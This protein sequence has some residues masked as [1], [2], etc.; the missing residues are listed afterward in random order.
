LL[1]LG[2][3]DRRIGLTRSFADALDDPR[4][5]GLTEHTFL[6]MVRARAYD[7]LAGYTD[8][9]DHNTL[10]AGPVFKRVA[11]RS[12]EDDDLASQPTLPRCE[13]AIATSSAEG[14]R[15]PSARSPGAGRLLPFRSCSCSALLGDRPIYPSLRER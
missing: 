14:R 11:G 5:P 4:D 13:N 9:N 12:P 3:F 10:R 2:Q 15:W 6:E 1:P 8:Q 7:I